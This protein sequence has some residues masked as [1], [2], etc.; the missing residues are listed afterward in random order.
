M[1]RT[2]DG[3]FALYKDKHGFVIGGMSGSR[4]REYELQLTPGSKLFVYTDG[5]PEA[6]N[7]A[8]ELFG[9]D[10][11]VNALNRVKDSDPMEILKSVEHG[12]A[13]FVGGAEQFDDLTMLC[14]EYK[15]EEQ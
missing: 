11:T 9:L 10:R 2:P 4:Y 5:V 6:T 1:V 15:G 14:L 7:S 13:E 12:V 8:E 3:C